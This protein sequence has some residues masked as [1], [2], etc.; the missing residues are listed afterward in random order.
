MGKEGRKNKNNTWK[1]QIR[2]LISIQSQKKKKALSVSNMEQV[3]QQYLLV[4]IPHSLS[5]NPVGP[6]DTEPVQTLDVALQ[7]MVM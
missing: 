1:F 3:P 5:P 6:C 4:H 7:P 2:S